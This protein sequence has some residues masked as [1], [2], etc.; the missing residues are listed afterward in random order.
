VFFITV[1]QVITRF[2]KIDFKQF[3]AAIHPHRNSRMVFYNF[4][5]YFWGQNCCWTETS[6]IRND[7]FC[8]SKVSI[9]FNSF[10]PS[11]LPLFRRWNFSQNMYASDYAKHLCICHKPF[12]AS[13]V[14]ASNKTQA[15]PSH[16]IA[17]H[18]PMLKLFAY[19]LCECATVVASELH[20][21][22]AT[23]ICLFINWATCLN[24]LR[25][26]L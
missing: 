6:I 16:L 23:D 24:R 20:S 13:N 8:V 3:I 4:C 2:T 17:A 9:A 1:S 26:L 15:Q 14:H 10:I 11:P 12:W 22:W 25:T 5:Y 7:S 18:N 19:L 21:R